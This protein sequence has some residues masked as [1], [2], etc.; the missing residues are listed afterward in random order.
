[1]ALRRMRRCKVIH[2][3]SEALESTFGKQLA[4]R[5]RQGTWGRWRLGTYHVCH[6]RFCEDYLSGIIHVRE[7]RKVVDHLPSGHSYDASTFV[8]FQ[9]GRH[10]GSI[11][12]R[13]DST[14]LVSVL[15]LN[16]LCCAKRNLLY[17]S[18]DGTISMPKRLV[19]ATTCL[20]NFSIIGC[21]PASP[22]SR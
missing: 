3:G 9:W 22:Y 11:R 15:R 10:I 19:D 21:D 7:P 13:E 6:H 18:P 14:L 8:D 16:Q 1:M 17:R 12:P 2:A 5:A 4:G 20:H